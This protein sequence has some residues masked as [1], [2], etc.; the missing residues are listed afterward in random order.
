[1]IKIKYSLVVG[2]IS[3]FYTT[4]SFGA[5]QLNLQTPVTPIAREIYGLHM[6]I[7]WFCV[8]IFIAVFGA[9]LYALLKHRK[10]LGHEAQQ[11]HENTLV[12]IIWTIMPFCILGVMAYPASKTILS[13]KNTAAPE[14]TI[15]VT[16]YQWKWGYDYLEEG[17]SFYSALSTPRDQ[18]ENRA[19]KGEHYLREVDNPMVVPTG[20]RIRVLLTASDVIHAWW[21]P[22]LGI[23]QDAIPGFIRDAWFSVETPG[24]YRG[25]CAELC[26]K[27]HGFMPIVV[28]AVEPEKYAAWLE[29]Q[30][31]KQA[32][33]QLDP[34]KV[35]ALEEFKTIGEK[36]YTANCVA[37]HQA[38][39]KGIPGVFKGLDGSPIATGPKEQ[40]V[41]I[42]MDGKPG[43]A[44]AAF[45]A[46]LSDTE[47]AAVITYERNSWGNKTGDMIQPSEIKAY[48]K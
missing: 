35:Y 21:V 40:H 29:E 2:L 24:T 4:L 45:A 34:N 16:G 11:F 46:L 36:V 23:K 14:M 6:A 28:E 7:L 12:E 5:Y 10:S 37:C 41:D 9:M 33:A 22:A 42:V 48:R 30:K 13:M 26:G 15:K 44:M 18:I 31:K 27:D 25:Q 20:K 32:A 3:T 38:D 47:I 39:G 43:T 8:G 17:V 19:P 1:M